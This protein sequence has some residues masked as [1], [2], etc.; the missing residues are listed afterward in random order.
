MKG[1][2]VLQKLVVVDTLKLR[3]TFLII[4]VINHQTYIKHISD[5]D[6][7]CLDNKMTT[8]VIYR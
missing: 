1:F 2:R 6:I 4:L 5:E 3:L 7:R 8:H